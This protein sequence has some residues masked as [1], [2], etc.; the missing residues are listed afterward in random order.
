MGETRGT[1]DVTS[2]DSKVILGDF[3]AQSF[4]IPVVGQRCCI[5]S[6]NLPKNVSNLSESH[7]QGS[8]WHWTWGHPPDLLL[9]NCVT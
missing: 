3:E 2:L 4:L 1:E 8:S 9:L 6:L 5:G 7:E